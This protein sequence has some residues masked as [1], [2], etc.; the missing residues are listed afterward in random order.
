[1]PTNRISMSK[2]R[3][4]LRLASQAKLSSREI[5]R[6]VGLSHAAV[7]SYLRRASEV[8]LAWPLAED[9]TDAELQKRLFPKPLAQQRPRPDWTKVHEELKGKGVTLRLLHAEYKERHPEGYAYTWFCDH[10]RDWKKSQDVVMRLEHTP[11]EKL[12]VDYAGMTVPV[13]DVEAREERPAQIFVAVLGC[14]NYTYAEATW[15]QKLED[16]TASHRRAFEFIG[17]VPAIV[18][19]DNLR[20]AVRKAHRYD[21]DLNPTYRDLAVHYGVGVLPARVRK[22]RDKAKAERGVLAVNQSILAVLRHERFLGLEELNRRMR[23]LLEKLNNKP[24]QKMDGCRRSWFEERDLPAMRPL[25]ATP[26]V[27]AEWKKAKVHVDYHVEVCHHRYSV[28]YRFTRCSVDVRL[29]ATTVECFLDGKRIASHARSQRRG[30]FT[31]VSEHTPPAHRTFKDTDKMLDRAARIGEATEKVANEILVRVRH[32]QQGFRSIRGILQLGQKH[33]RDRLERAC[34]RALRYG[35]C[36]YRSVASILKHGL[37]DRPEEKPTPAPVHDN[38]RGGDYYAA[39]ST[40]HHHIN[41]DHE[42]L[43]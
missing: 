33:G 38:I 39:P 25:P 16:W 12:F 40:S 28:P 24:F 20:S 31:T 35:A 41:Q 2:F 13:W 42:K 22:P 27:F 43:C 11:G 32:P 14:S 17:A 6:S 23:P 30:G 7:N 15:T 29:T 3:E 8:G 36:S 34:Q 1:M 21:P 10:Y 37:E 5:G 19:C 18:V 9:I 4:V 26:Y